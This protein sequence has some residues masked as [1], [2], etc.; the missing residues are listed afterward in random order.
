MGVRGVDVCIFNKLDQP[1]TVAFDGNP[2]LQGSP[3]VEPGAWVCGF[4]GTNDSVSGDIHA[5]ADHRLHFDAANAWIYWPTLG[6]QVWR[7]DS[8]TCGRG[9]FL[10]EGDTNVINRRDVQYAGGRNSDD[11]YWKY[12]YVNVEPSNNSTPETCPGS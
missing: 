12:F 10:N 8:M 11:D 6:L 2:G 5:L 4:D 1:I 3:D 7:G 9:E